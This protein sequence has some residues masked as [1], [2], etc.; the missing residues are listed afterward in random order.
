MHIG[1]RR[2]AAWA[3]CV[4]GIAFCAL[5]TLA[6]GQNRRREISLEQY[7]APAGRGTIVGIV[8]AKETGAPLPFADLLQATYAFAYGGWAPLRRR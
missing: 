1:G 7:N 3:R 5:S 8:T 6:Q 2:A 4:A